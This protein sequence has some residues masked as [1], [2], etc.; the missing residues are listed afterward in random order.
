MRRRRRAEPIKVT[1]SIWDASAVATASRGKLRFMPF[2]E[3]V[4]LSKL[5]LVRTLNGHSR[6]VRCGVRC[7]FVMI[8]LRRR[9]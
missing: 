9:S 3:G 8:W 6:E 1:Q 7:T 2:F 5:A 4:D